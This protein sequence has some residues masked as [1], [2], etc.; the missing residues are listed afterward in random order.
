MRA[1]TGGRGWIERRAIITVAT[2]LFVAL[3]MS[4][5]PAQAGA[6]KCSGRETDPDCALYVIARKC[7]DTSDPDY[8]SACPSPRAG[9]CPGASTCEKTTEVWT[10]TSRMIAI[11]DRTMCTCPEVIHGLVIPTGAVTG[12]EDPDR[13]PAIWLLA[14]KAAEAAGLTVDQTALIANPPDHRTQNQL[15]IHVLPIDPAKVTSLETT[16]SVT[17]ADLK[18]V[19]QAADALAASNGMTSFGIVVHR[20]GVAWHVHV[21]DAPLPEA[22]TRL[23]D[24]ARTIR[25]R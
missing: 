15:H 13:P 16:P 8:C 4:P 24:C 17:V 22:Y 25:K 2:I 7:V 21:A 19:W 9:Y 3:P 11:R 1:P 20:S 18:G 6:T 23:P 10:G 5:F 12:V 14:S